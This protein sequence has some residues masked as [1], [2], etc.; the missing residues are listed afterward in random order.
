M[1]SVLAWGAPS[2]QLVAVE[3]TSYDPTLW[4]NPSAIISG[5]CRPEHKPIKVKTQYPH[6]F[7]SANLA[8][9]RIRRVSAR[10]ELGPRP[11]PAVETVQRPGPGL[12]WPG[13]FSPDS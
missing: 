7:A 1:G 9:T 11:C 6:A 13:L 4:V 3:R 5:H 10:H 12:L 2:E 8:V